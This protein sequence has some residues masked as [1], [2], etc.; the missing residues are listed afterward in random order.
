MFEVSARI[1]VRP[2]PKNVRFAMAAIDPP[3]SPKRSTTATLASSSNVHIV[4][5]R[6]FMYP[7]GKWVGHWDQNGMGRQSMHD[8]TIRFE[9]HLLNG[10][11][12]DCVGEF[13][14]SGE[15]QP[16]GSV[17]IVKKYLARHSVIYRGHHDGE[18]LIFGVWAL[19]GD[20]GTWAIRPSIGF[21]RSA[22]PISEILPG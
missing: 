1:D 18:G 3:D 12:W 11:G 19:E 6:D 8:L 14:L 5:A 10:K 2:R 21:Q 15:I 7:S 9:D 22:A 20:E 13:T 17:S 4:A 16:D